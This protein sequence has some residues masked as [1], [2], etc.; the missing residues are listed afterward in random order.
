M[1]TLAIRLEDD[2]HAELQAIAQLMGSTITDEIRTAIVSHI[3]A[4]K[5]NP[6]LTEAAQALL[7]EIERD[8]LER[9][10][11]VNRLLGQPQPHPSRSTGGRR[12]KEQKGGGDEEPVS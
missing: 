5:G 8:A 4:S 2:L 11:A 12:P 3:E 7:D 9:R 10:T 1:K 6:K